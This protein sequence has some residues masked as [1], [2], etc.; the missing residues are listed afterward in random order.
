[1]GYENLRWK[2]YKWVGGLGFLMSLN[3]TWIERASKDQPTVNWGE[4]VV[5]MSF[6]VM[7]R[8]RRLCML[9]SI[10]KRKDTFWK[11]II[12]N[13]KSRATIFCLFSN[14]RF[15]GHFSTSFTKDFT[16]KRFIPSIKHEQFKLILGNTCN[17]DV[18]Y[19]A[20]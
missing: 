13:N 10:L 19:E 1:M 8:Q 3:Q 6:Y 2:L 18:W 14:K 7:Q 4:W 11:K 5:F 9:S 20:S 17:W 16:V 12:W 15:N